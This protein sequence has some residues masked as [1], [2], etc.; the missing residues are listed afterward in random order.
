MSINSFNAAGLAAA[1]KP[2]GDPDFDITD[3]C[4]AAVDVAYEYCIKEFKKAC[5]SVEI[6]WN[7]K[8]EDI[9]YG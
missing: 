2:L 1:K 7:K 3:Y 8:W 6:E 5:K 9:L 4:N